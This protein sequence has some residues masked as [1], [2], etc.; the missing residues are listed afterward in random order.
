MDFLYTLASLRNPV[1]NAIMQA[2]TYFGEELLFMAVALVLFW[3]VDKWK[4]YYILAVGFLGTI[5]TQWLKLVY[6]VPRPWK[7]DPSIL[8]PSA[9]SGATGYSFPSGHSQS[10]V[11]TFGGIARFAKKTWLR[12]VLILLFALVA[13]SR[14]YLGAHFPTD[15]AVGLAIGIVL[16]FVMYPIVQRASKSPRWMYGLLGCMVL[17]N[18]A[19][20]A[21]VSLYPFPADVMLGDNYTDNYLEGLANGW[22]LLGALLGLTLAYTVDWKKLHFSEKAPLLGQICKIVIGLL[23]V[24]G[25]QKGLKPVFKRISEEPYWDAI[26]YFLVVVFAGAIWPLTLPIWQK[27]G[28][29]KTSK[30]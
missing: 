7:R 14:M 4:G 17:I 29:K 6:R 13:F 28:V 1:L 22:K 20:V 26:R 30:S 27:V 12:I 23:L 5:A 3:C 25:I 16:V 18:I 9:K 24:V 19:Y 10:A 21:Y 2:V 11:C 8:V 15:V